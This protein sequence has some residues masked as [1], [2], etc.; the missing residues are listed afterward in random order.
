M[1]YIW[2]VEVQP[3]SLYIWNASMLKDRGNKASSLNELRVLLE[4]SFLSCQYIIQD[5]VNNK[6]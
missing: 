5:S 3:V 1:K 4:N 2:L 6:C